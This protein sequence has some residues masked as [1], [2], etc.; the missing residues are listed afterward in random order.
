MLN[1]NDYRLIFSFDVKTI[2]I[3]GRCNEFWSYQFPA[4]R[5]SDSITIYF[6]NTT[7]TRYSTPDTTGKLIHPCIIKHHPL[8]QKTKE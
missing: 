7:I 1:G 3:M 6:L 4:D 8:L 2:R 5:F